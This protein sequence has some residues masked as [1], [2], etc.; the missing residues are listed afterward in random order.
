MRPS[1][2]LP[3]A[4]AFLSGCATFEEDVHLSPLFSNLSTAGGG[5]EVEAL[6][7]SIRV[8]RP[9]PSADV[10][11]WAWR[12]L[13]S[14]KYEDNGD[15]ALRYVVP[16]GLRTERGDET[17]TRFSPIY[18]YHELYDEQRR[19]E[20]R[21]LIFP[22]VLW[23]KNADG[24]VVRA[25][26]PLGGVIE[27]FL[28]YDQIVFGLFPVYMRTV[29]GERTS[30]HVLWPIFGYSNE[31]GRKSYRFWPFYGVSRDEDHERYFALWPIFH[32]HENDLRKPEE[33]R[34]TKK[35]VLP[36]YGTTERDTFRSWGVLW[37]FFG[38]SRDTAS[39]FRSFDGPWP[40]VRI[41]R[42]GE[43]E[44]A[45]RTRLWPLY[46]FYRDQAL[47]STWVPWP[48]YNR[49]VET[50]HDGVRRAE[51]FI[52]FWQN[53]RRT[54]EDGE[55]LRTWTKFW[56]LYQEY[57][58]GDHSRTALPALNP[59]WHTPVVDDH[60]AWVYELYTREEEATGKRERA[61]GNLWRRDVDG[62]EERTYLTGLWS[63]RKYTFRGEKVRETSLLL[64]L[65]RWRED[66]DGVHWMRP[67]MPGPGWPAERMPATEPLSKARAR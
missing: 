13:V 29:R 22:I 60:Y 10:N 62:G 27:R 7:G 11:E 26:F 57:T 33:Q 8:R 15:A 28:S 56:P 17:V 31:D 54:G 39:G 58:A 51:F 67:A 14:K 4:A 38:W 5:R 66:A 48:L 47:E 43:S 53:W 30:H 19:P 40:L 63:R 16:F 24:R 25:L 20:W 23:S 45:Y 32:W 12:P 46:S 3:L 42:P 2:L 37:P 55:E 65:L 9:L 64:G 50:Y 1:A 18:R 41:Q 61:W 34:E 52:P 49:R 59:L 21:L 44:A 36:F 6:A 35:G